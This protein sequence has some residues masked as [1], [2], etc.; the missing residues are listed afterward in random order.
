[1]LQSAF[2]IITPQCEA[3]ESLEQCWPGGIA[4]K[5]H[6]LSTF[7]R[8]GN[9]TAV[10][11]AAES[12]QIERGGRTVINGLSFGVASGEALVLSGPNGAGKT[13]LLR[14][15]AGFLPLAAGRIQLEGGDPEL[16]LGEQAHAVGHLN[17]I[18]ANLTVAENVAFWSAFLG[19][20]KVSAAGVERALDHFGLSGLAAFP[21]AYLSA[22]QRR[23]VG[24]ARLLASH[25]PVWLLDEPTA[26][27]DAASSVRVTEAVNT[28]T[29]GGGI[30]IA[31]THL[32][33]DLERARELS[34]D[35]ERRAA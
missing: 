33:L 31:A 9:L 28:H 7:C 22:G 5:C 24:L 4:I 26:S 8:D 21:A 14:A 11:I 3:N 32:P 2:Y 25:R 15:L 35:P 13:T 30:V 6:P 34:I 29:A 16:T 1:M 19:D 27:L 17:A 20:G 10:H 23:R 12:L 18:K